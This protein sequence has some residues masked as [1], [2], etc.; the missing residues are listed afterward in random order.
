MSE[1]KRERI[2]LD[3]K[4]NT[5]PD[6][7]DRDIVKVL[8]KNLKE[9]YVFWGISSQSFEKILNAFQCIREEIY[10]KLMINYKQE[11]KIQRHK[12]IYLPPFT[13]N[14]FLQFEQKIKNLKVEVVAYTKTGNTYSLLH[15]AEISIPNHKPS[16]VIHK[17]W[18]K[19]AWI[20]EHN[21]VEIN[22]EILMQDGPPA[23]GDSFSADSTKSI[24]ESLSNEILDWNENVTFTWSDGSSGFMGSS[25]ILASSS[26]HMRKSNEQ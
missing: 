12:E 2:Y 19:P 1:E 14:W 26:N 21:L 11:D 25:G 10:F 6:Y 23:K 7:Y 17:D 20:K 16:R 4:L 8:T 18:I 15:S 13:N 24:N 22:G 3:P 5:L 9:A